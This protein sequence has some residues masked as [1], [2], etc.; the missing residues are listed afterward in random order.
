MHLLLPIFCLSLHIAFLS[1]LFIIASKLIGNK[2]STYLKSKLNEEQKKIY[3]E[4]KK[5]RKKHYIM[6]L[7]FGIIV[8][9]LYNIFQGKNIKHM[10][11]AYLGISTF[12]A[13]KFYLLMPKKYWMIEHLTDKEDIIAWNNVYKRM[14]YLTSYAELAGFITFGIS[15]YYF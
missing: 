13:N 5:E 1:N 3:S 6:G 12:I 9:I 8:A 14:R 4:I 7:V 15:Q 2:E 11:C 10:T